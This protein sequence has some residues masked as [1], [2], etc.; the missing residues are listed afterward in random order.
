MIRIKGQ[1]FIFKEQRDGSYY[2]INVKDPLAVPHFYYEPT[3]GFSMYNLKKAIHRH[4]DNF[5]PMKRKLKEKE[6][7]QRKR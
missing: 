5:T 4:C 3:K 1:R 2:V 7:K 6:N